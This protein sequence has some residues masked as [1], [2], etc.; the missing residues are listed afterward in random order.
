MYQLSFRGIATA[1]FV[2]C[3]P[4]VSAADAH[5]AALR[6]ATPAV[7]MHS[8]ADAWCLQGDTAGVDCSF[9]NRSQCEATA[10]GGLGECVP[11]MP[12]MRERD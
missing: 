7:F 6:P 2:A 10:A 9:S 8:N 1:L 12:G 4:L 11:M 3:A 5:A